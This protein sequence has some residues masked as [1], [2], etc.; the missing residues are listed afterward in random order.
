MSEGDAVPRGHEHAAFEGPLLWLMHRRWV[1]LGMRLK[2][3]TKKTI[4]DRSD[5]FVLLDSPVRV[6]MS[7]PQGDDE[8]VVDT[9]YKLTADAGWYISNP[10]SYTGAC[11][12]LDS[13]GTEASLAKKFELHHAKPM[14]SDE[15]HFPDAAASSGMPDF[16]KA[17]ESAS[18][19]D[20]MI[21]QLKTM[22][23]SGAAAAS[24]PQTAAGSP[25]KKPIS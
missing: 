16:A 2:G 1:S 4:D 7:C 9:G 24:A 20:D 3:V 5:Y 18:G 14:H 21:A 11:I 23:Q 8:A 13:D 25:A 15:F 6:I 12:C 19:V 10:H 22:A 17:A